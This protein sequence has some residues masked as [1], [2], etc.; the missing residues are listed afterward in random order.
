MNEAGSLLTDSV[1]LQASISDAMNAARVAGDIERFGI[2]AA[3]ETAIGSVC[4]ILR[5]PRLHHGIDGA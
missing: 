3:A 1:R 5:D 2:L 4:N